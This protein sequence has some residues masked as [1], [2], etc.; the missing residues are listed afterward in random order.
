MSVEID[1]AQSLAHALELL[2][3]GDPEVRPV[4]GATDVVLRL[5]M[6]R[7]KAK[8]LVSIADLAELAWI[9]PEAGGIRF[10]AGTWLTDLMTHPEFAAEFPG[11]VESARQFASPQI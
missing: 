6:G 11:A 5:H 3:A 4:A 9:K 8:R 1:V 7:L 2:S 10:G